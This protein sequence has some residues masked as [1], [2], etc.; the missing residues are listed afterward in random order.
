MDNKTNKLAGNKVALIK[1]RLP[2]NGVAASISFLITYGSKVT[3]AA[4]KIFIKIIITKK[5]R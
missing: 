5:V 4:T 3:Y 1:L 2:S